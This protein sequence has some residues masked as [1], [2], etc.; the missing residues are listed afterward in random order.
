MS[1]DVYMDLPQIEDEVILKTLE[2]FEII[3]A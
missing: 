2:A 3:Y 1:K